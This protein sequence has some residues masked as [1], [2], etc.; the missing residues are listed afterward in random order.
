MAISHLKKYDTRH[1]RKNHMH[2]LCHYYAGYS[3]RINPTA[4]EKKYENHKK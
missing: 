4:I 3:N 2:N 1:I